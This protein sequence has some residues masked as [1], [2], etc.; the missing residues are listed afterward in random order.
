MSRRLVLSG[1]AAMAA[2]LAPG[3][4]AGGETAP[5]RIVKDAVYRA[6]GG[7]PLHLDLYIHPAARERSGPVLV[8]FHGGGWARGARPESWTGFRP[9][10]AAGFSVVTVEYRL[11][12]A[13]RAPAAVED[14]RCALHWIHTNAERYGFDRTRIVVSG[15]SAGAHLA[16]MAGLLPDENAIDPAECRGA[17]RAAAIVDLYGPT[18]LTATK[19]ASGARHATVANWIGEGDGADAMAHRM[20]PVAWLRSDIPPIFIGHGDADPVVPVAQSIDLKRRLDALAVPADLFI[21]PGGGHGKFDAGSQRAMTARVLAFLC[22]RR[23]PD[24]RACAEKN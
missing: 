14:A 8:Y 10:I 16:L 2:L 22:G 19:D 9:Y 11:A 5:G 18:D 7:R 24:P 23:I 13:A 15:T 21:V 17:G 12:G 1:I 20:S 3:A 6:V 4:S